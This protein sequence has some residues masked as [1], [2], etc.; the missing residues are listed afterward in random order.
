MDTSFGTWIQGQISKSGQ[1]LRTLS[2]LSGLHYTTISRMQNGRVEAT[3]DSAIRIAKSVNADFDSLY[4][5][6]YGVQPIIPSI[7][8][9]DQHL[10]P[11]KKD[12]EAVEIA[13]QK[14]PKT[15][16]NFFSKYLNRIINESINF[17][18]LQDEKNIEISWL[19]NSL[20]KQK[21][22]EEEVLKYF[23][24]VGTYSS[25]LRKTSLLSY[26]LKIEPK[27]IIETYL[28][29]GVMLKDDIVILIDEFDEKLR[30]EKYDVSLIKKH[31]KVIQLSEYID[32]TSQISRLKLSDLL[33]I[34]NVVSEKGEIFMIAW[35]AAA[36]ELRQEASL[37]KTGVS[38]LLL[39]LGRYLTLIN[40][41][42]PNWLNRL[43]EIAL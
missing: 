35:N 16:C 30:Y 4:F 21:I 41:P 12:L 36:E 27:S 6:L 15:I 18:S 34:D 3:L 17:D 1:D 20:S 5:H 42:E 11:T 38:R 14:K 31:M 22:T 29:S 24:Q 40:N 39:L 33:L 26:P 25:I 13:F 10:F 43:N 2:R 28:G 19:K 7:T 9:Y 23:L 32:Q 37:Y 8:S